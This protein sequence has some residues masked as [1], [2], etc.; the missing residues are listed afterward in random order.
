MSASIPAR[1]GPQVDLQNMPPNSNKI[2]HLLHLSE[3][4][5]IVEKDLDIFYLEAL[6]KN[7]LPFGNILVSENDGKKATNL[8]EIKRLLGLRTKSTAD[9]EQNEVEI[10]EA[11]PEIQLLLEARVILF[12]RRHQLDAQ[13]LTSFEERF[14]MFEQKSYLIVMNLVK[15]Q[16]GLDLKATTLLAVSRQPWLRM[17][18]K[19]PLYNPSR[20]TLPLPPAAA[21]DVQ[22]VMSSA[23]SKKKHTEEECPICAFDLYS[24]KEKYSGI[25]AKTIPVCCGSCNREYHVEC[26]LTWFKEVPGRETC[27]MCR[28]VVDY[29]FIFKLVSV[30]IAELREIEKVLAVTQDEAVA[31]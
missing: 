7:G 5:S 3:S 22:S 26:L 28:A 20:I 17:W 16:W 30:R 24:Q 14:E 27:P 18:L 15:E 21:A 2:I 12:R 25:M 6:L 29:A 13:L 9:L 4:F 1:T 19:G 23:D 31:K 11:G 10:S 8:R